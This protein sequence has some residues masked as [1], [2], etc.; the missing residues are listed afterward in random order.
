MPKNKQSKSLGSL[1]NFATRTDTH[2]ETGPRP[3]ETPHFESEADRITALEKRVA[4]LE[5]LLNDVMHQLDTPDTQ[6]K[7]KVNGKPKGNGKPKAQKS[8]PPTP[9]PKKDTPKK[10]PPSEILTALLKQKP[11]SRSEIE[12]ATGMDTEAVRKCVIWMT[13]QDFIEKTT[14]KDGDGNSRWSLKQ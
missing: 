5:L 2:I 13:N 14:D 1:E 8:K 9:K 11:H 10:T 3:S 6:P 4:T 7:S 12:A